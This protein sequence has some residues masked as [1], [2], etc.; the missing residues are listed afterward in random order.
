MADNSN[1]GGLDKLMQKYGALANVVV[2]QNIE[3]AIGAS[4]H[5]IQAEAKLMCPVNDGELRQSIKTEVSTQAGK[6][7]GTIY[8][9]KKHG[10][11]VEFGTGPKGEADH[12]G[13]S[14][15]VSPSYT[16][17][18]W[19]IHESQID[20]ATAEKYNMFYIDT[21]EGRFYQSSGQAAQPFMYPALKNNEERATRNIKNYLAR[22][23]RK[24]VQD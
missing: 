15:E 1:I 3:R 10:P 6:V 18:P 16:Q 7:I 14:P 9:N 19:W 5:I 12:A 8:T 23:I 4:T 24:A 13:I 22:E 11:Y 21:P 17:S 20:A 2:G